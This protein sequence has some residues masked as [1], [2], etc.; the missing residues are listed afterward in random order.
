MRLESVDQMSI[1]G[2]GE[3]LATLSSRHPWFWAMN[4]VG[5][6]FQWVKELHTLK[7]VRTFFPLNIPVHPLY[8]FVG[9]SQ[10]FKSENV[11]VNTQQV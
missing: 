5:W 6:C 10:D 8:S 9:W 1:T 4:Q 2:R 3:E 7:L 11:A